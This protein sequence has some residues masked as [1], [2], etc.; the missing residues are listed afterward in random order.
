MPERGVNPIGKIREIVGALGP[1]EVVVPRS[2]FRPQP[3]IETLS[4]AG[5]V[6]HISMQGTTHLTWFG[7]AAT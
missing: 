5:A 4:R 6:I 3:L 2:T 1:G 7:R